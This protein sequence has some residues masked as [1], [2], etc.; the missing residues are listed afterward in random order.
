MKPNRLEK[1]KHLGKRLLS[2]IAGSILGVLVATVVA[3][4]S[5]LFA[6]FWAGPSGVALEDPLGYGMTGFK[7]AVADSFRLGWLL[8]ALLSPILFLAFIDRSWWLRVVLW[9][10]AGAV[11]GQFAFG[12]YVRHGDAAGL[13]M[14]PYGLYCGLLA[15]PVHRGLWS[16]VAALRSGLTRLHQ[17]ELG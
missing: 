14:A 9:T 15:E 10:V 12:G 4:C 1:L 8:G 11:Y 7:L 2:N 17:Q 5:G 13:I 16:A 6:P 3:G